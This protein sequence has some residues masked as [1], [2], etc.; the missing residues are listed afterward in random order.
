MARRLNHLLQPKFKTPLVER[1]SPGNFLRPIRE[2]KGSLAG[3]LALSFYPVPHHH[4]H[5]HTHTHTNY[6][7]T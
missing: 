7:F 5:T 4:Y 1:H 6:S 3:S 2:L